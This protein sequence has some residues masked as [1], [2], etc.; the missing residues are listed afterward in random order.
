MRLCASVHDVFMPDRCIHVCPLGVTAICLYVLCHVLMRRV[1]S[2]TLRPHEHHTAMR[3]RP[4]YPS[5]DTSTH[6]RHIQHTLM[7]SKAC[8]TQYPTRHLYMPH[9]VHVVLRQACTFRMN[10]H[11]HISCSCHYLIDDHVCMFHARI[12]IEIP[13]LFHAH[14]P[15]RTRG[16]HATRL[17]RLCA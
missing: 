6:R 12:M 11:V 4:T 2:H 14:P 13:P 3:C 7:L 9:D 15:A 10:G 5:T 17:T 16:D 1:C 8:V